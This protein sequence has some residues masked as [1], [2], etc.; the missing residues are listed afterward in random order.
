[1]KAKQLEQL[2]HKEIPISQAM[3]IEVDHLDKNTISV[4]APFEKNKNI[5]NTAFAG[6]IYTTATLAGWSLLT[7]Y[8]QANNIDGAVV[9][10]KANIK[11]LRPIN[12]DIIAYC[13]LSN[14]ETLTD[15]KGHIEIKKRAKIELNIT[16]KEQALVKAK[17]NAF[18]AI[19]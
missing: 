14:S 15:L 19:V 1:M 6:S 17:M 7:H 10:A 3:G 16:V 8:L 13:D 4:R 9:L 5:H 2:L 18:F 12:Q 11:Y